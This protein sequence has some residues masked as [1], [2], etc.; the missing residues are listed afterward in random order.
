MWVQHYENAFFFPLELFCY[1][2]VAYLQGP[3]HTNSTEMNIRKVAA[4]SY[5]PNS[6]LAWVPIE[7]NKGSLVW[8]QTCK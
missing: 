2:V 5:N 7:L 8:K 4:I 1:L 3:G 6:F